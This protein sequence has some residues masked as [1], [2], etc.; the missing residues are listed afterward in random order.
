[1]Y[2]VDAMHI[3]QSIRSVGQLNKSVASISA[4]YGTVTHE[5]STIDPFMI[6]YKFVDVAVIHPLGYHR[7]PVLFQVHTNERENVR[8]L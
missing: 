8:V 1:M 7:K 6:L 3:L 5:L 2:H 4:I